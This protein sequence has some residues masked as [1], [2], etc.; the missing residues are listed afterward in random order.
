MIASIFEPSLALAI[1]SPTGDP[2]RLEDDPALSPIA[3]LGLRED[4]TE[5]GKDGG[6]LKLIAEDPTPS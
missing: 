6:I 5:V 2:L 4:A 3:L 1:K